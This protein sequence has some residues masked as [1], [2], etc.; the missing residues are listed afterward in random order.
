MHSCLFWKPTEDD[1]FVRFKDVGQCLNI[2]LPDCSMT[3]CFKIKW[4][5]TPILT[6]Q[7][8]AIHRNCPEPSNGDSKG[9]PYLNGRV[10]D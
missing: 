10:D 1:L 3:L 8:P 7:F 5:L 4:N 6:T 2:L 9:S